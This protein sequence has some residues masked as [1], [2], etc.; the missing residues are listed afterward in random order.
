MI[1]SIT[2]ANA[3]T[4]GSTP[5]VLNE[6]A[7]FTYIFGANAT[8]KT[9]ISRVIADENA[10]PSCKVAWRGGTRL[11]PMVY[12]QDFVER[13]FNQSSEFK[14]VFTLG[15]Q[16][17]GT[18]KKI[19]SAKE[20]LDNLTTKIETLS[21]TLQGSDGLGGKRAELDTLEND[22]KDKC[23]EQKKKYDSKFHSAFEGYR[24]NSEKFKAKV[25]HELG[26]NTVALVSLAELERR[27][28]TVFGPTPAT[29]LSIPTFD[30]SSLG[31]HQANPI[32]KKKVIGK[33]DVDIAAMIGKLGNSD[34]VREGRVFY[35]VNAGVC[36][37]CQQVTTESLAKSLSEYFD[38]T[39]LKESKS[40]S[41]LASSYKT[42][43]ERAQQQLTSIITTP[44]KFL[45]LDKL[46][47]EK[48]LLD[49]K[50]IINIQR[51][52]A[53]KKEPSQVVELDSHDNV[54]A[55]IVS[56]IDSANYR[57]ADHN[58]IVS[59][60]AKERA[61]L[62]E[63]VWR[64][65]LEELKADLGAYKTAREGKDKAI[66]ALTDQITAA[67][68]EKGEKADEIR[69]LEKLTTSV[70]P[71]IDAINALLQSFG[72]HSFTLTKT[73]HSTS[74]KL[75]RSDGTDAKA[76]LSEGERSFVTFLYFYHLLKGSNTESGMTTDRIVVFDDPVS[77]FD[78]DILFI[79]ASLIKGLLDEVRDGKSHIKQVFVLTHNVYFHKE[80]T[81]NQNRRGQTMN[82]ETF[83]I[84][85]RPGKISML[86]RHQSNPIKTSYEL[87]WSE[88]RN[89]NRSKLTI[90]NTLRRILENYFK[91]LGGIDLVSLCTMFEGRDRLICKSL[92]S[93]IHDGSHYAH[94]DFFVAIDDA[95]VDAYLEVFK[96]IFEKS[97][98]IAHYRMMTGEMHAG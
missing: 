83:W 15:E 6:L 49:S 62:T 89:Q 20:D 86:E 68:A 2:I 45:E 66:K 67:K 37:F 70:Q 98:H 88:V 79:V 31:V 85:R 58:K 59:N 65:L 51:L 18:L 76:T 14:G 30:M 38:D 92:C 43:S 73:A 78:S 77:S 13:N 90:Q 12:N 61:D 21:R 47:S 93:W 10:F 80:V 29:E 95:M 97:G 39:F 60:I 16:N 75:V 35:D 87:L 94:D 27:A 19:E 91:I 32:L 96:K 41:D 52:S 82:E 53:K 24:N 3:A 50:I 46:K 22:L 5:Q 1:E 48:E 71:T 72:F 26:R 44:S 25:L 42:D 23:W 40:I 4:Y 36:P 74:Y 7:F 28:E 34:W 33:D 54:F 63:Q 69:E 55:A 17:I 57:I 56:L 11:Q 8:G 9:T 81:F 64:F 84:L